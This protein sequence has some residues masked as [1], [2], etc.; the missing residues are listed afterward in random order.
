MN[1]TTAQVRAMYAAAE[2]R[3]VS[4]VHTDADLEAHAAQV[5]AMYAD[6][7]REAEA[8]QIPAEDVTFNGKCEYRADVPATYWEK[9]AENCERRRQESWERS[10]DDGF[11]S[12]WANQEMAARYLRAASIARNGYVD[13]FRVVAD[14]DGNVLSDDERKGDYGYYWLIRSAQGKERFFKESTAV[15]KETALR[16][17]ARKGRVMVYASAPVEINYDADARMVS[18]AE[19]TL[20]AKALETIQAARKLAG[21]DA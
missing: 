20:D 4:D 1:T 13:H 7:H 11:L 10:D 18:G 12:Q 2:E 17:N 14:L 16:N 15:K 6:A 21:L 3:T 5:R 19:Y 9:E 8:A